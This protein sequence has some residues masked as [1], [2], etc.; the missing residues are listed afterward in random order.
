MRRLQFLFGSALFL[1]AAVLGGCATVPADH[2]AAPGAAMS[3]D[4]GDRA[5]HLRQQAA[6]LRNLAKRFEFE[7]D[8]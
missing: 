4:P 6:E 1:I 5:F 8:W 2:P 3:M 7:A